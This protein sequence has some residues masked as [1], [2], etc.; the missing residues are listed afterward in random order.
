[1]L[2]VNVNVQSTCQ[3]W[4]QNITIFTV[5]HS[6]QSHYKG[7]LAGKSEDVDQQWTSSSSAAYSI[8]IAIKHRSYHNSQAEISRKELHFGNL[9]SLYCTRWYFYFYNVVEV[10]A[11]AP[12]GDIYIYLIENPSP[13]TPQKLKAY[14]STD[15]NLIFRRGWVHN[16]V[17]WKVKTNKHLHYQSKDDCHLIASYQLASY[18]LLASSL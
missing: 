8:T 5:I 11:W 3:T 14:K 12:V 15:S 9:W 6:F 2:N 10:P 1:M 7:Y 13:Y 4:R 18:M 16:D 17:V